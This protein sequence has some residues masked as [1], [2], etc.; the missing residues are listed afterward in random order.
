M[1]SCGIPESR[2]KTGSSPP[3]KPLAMSCE[4]LSMTRAGIRRPSSTSGSGAGA[5]ITRP[6]ARSMPSGSNLKLRRLCRYILAGLRHHDVAGAPRLVVGDQPALGEDPDEP[7]EGGAL[8][9]VAGAAASRGHQLVAVGVLEPAFLL[10]LVE[11]LQQGD[12]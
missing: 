7:G 3:L 8:P 4:A 1:C 9:V 10:P 6:R 2:R 5:V 11:Q 12:V